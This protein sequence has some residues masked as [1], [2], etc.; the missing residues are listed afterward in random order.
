MDTERLLEALPVAVYT[1]DAE[2]RITF[3]NQA[4][5]ELWGYR[6]ALGS[7]WCGSWKLYWPDGRP[8]PHDE[9]P[10][11]IALKEGREVRGVEAVAERPDGMRV[12]FAPYPTPFKDASGRVEG[13]INV[14]VEIGTRKDA[15]AIAARFADVTR[16][17][18]VASGSDRPAGRE[19][20]LK[21]EE[22]SWLRSAY[23]DLETFL[24]GHLPAVDAGSALVLVLT[25]RDHRPERTKRALDMLRAAAVLEVRA[26]AILAEPLDRDVPAELTRV[27]RILVPD[28][29]GLPAP[30][31]ALLGSATP[32]QLISER[33]GRARGT[34]PDPI[35]RDDPAYLRAAEVADAPEA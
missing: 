21:V 11:A 32:L 24:H 33:L 12:P 5:A 23:R 20:V 1:T 19:L 9:C 22:G 13:A 28:A 8:L 25:D 3:F 27:G 26:A 16:L 17:L 35:R 30:V 29:P 4:A 18:V 10:M 7:L 34:N 31:A 6:P 15:E 14:L 2:G